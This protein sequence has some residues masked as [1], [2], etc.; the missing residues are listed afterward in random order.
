VRI[1]FE[2]DR[3]MIPMLRG[4]LSVRVVMKGRSMHLSRTNEI[5]LIYRDSI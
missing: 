3:L 5:E 2:G 4:S 1:G